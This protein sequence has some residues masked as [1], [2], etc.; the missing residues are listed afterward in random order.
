MPEIEWTEVTDSE[1]IVAM[2]YDEEEESIYVRFPKG[3]VEWCYEDCPPHIWDE[4]S[5]SGQSKGLYIHETLNH[6]PNHRHE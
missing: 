3:G 1:R 5:A 6:K 4:F 2:A